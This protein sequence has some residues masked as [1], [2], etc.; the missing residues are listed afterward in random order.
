MKHK[1]FSIVFVIVVVFSLF[2]TS[3]N[4]VVD[5][6]TAVNYLSQASYYLGKNVVYGYFTESGL[7]ANRIPSVNG[8]G[9]LR[10]GVW[11]IT[12]SITDFSNIA[13][14]RV[15]ATT[16]GYEVKSFSELPP[17]L[18][19]ALI[20]SLMP[21]LT[22]IKS[23]LF[24]PF[25]FPITPDMLNPIP[26]PQKTSIDLVSAAG[27]TYV[28]LNHI[29]VYYYGFGPERFPAFDYNGKPYR[30]QSQPLPGC[31]MLLDSYKRW[32]YAVRVQD[33]HCHHNVDF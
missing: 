9:E 6:K 2:M 16:L 13:V 14:M 15:K 26:P 30:L 4:I 22:A 3:C 33:S 7:R 18:R 24:T 17:A 29:S 8:V 10:N 25:V 23:G 31:W 19:R 5:E 11:S 28:W 27:G 20:N 12:G 1:N 32:G 21:V